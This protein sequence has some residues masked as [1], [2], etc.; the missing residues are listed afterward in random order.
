MIIQ[1]VMKDFELDLGVEGLGK[2]TL[3]K[4]TR[5]AIIMSRLHIDGAVFENLHT[6]KWDP[7]ID[8]TKIFSKNGNALPNP[9]RPFGGGSSICPGR[10]FA[11]YELKLFL[12]RLFCDYEIELINN[13]IPRVD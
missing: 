5:V 11:V 10:N 9:V 13:N 4:G 6:F 8:P 3:L 1:Q 7:F 12:A 2:Y